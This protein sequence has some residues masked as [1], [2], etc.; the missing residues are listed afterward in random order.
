MKGSIKMFLGQS[1]EQ[2]RY[3]T[4]ETHPDID[5]CGLSRLTNDA[6]GDVSQDLGITV[7]SS[8]FD[9]TLSLVADDFDRTDGPFATRT[10]EKVLGGRDGKIVGSLGREVGR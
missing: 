7:L 3:N 4:G 8:N 9:R 1:R 6:D 2:E 5:T 10:N